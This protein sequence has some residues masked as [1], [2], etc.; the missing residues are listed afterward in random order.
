VAR[1]SGAAADIQKNVIFM[2]DVCAN[3]AVSNII[4]YS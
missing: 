2:L 1:T 4:R 3:E